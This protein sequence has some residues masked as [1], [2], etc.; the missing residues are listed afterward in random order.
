MNTTIEYAYN[1]FCEERFPI[2]SERQVADLER[3]M[4]ASFP[5]DYRDYL[6]RY[7]GGLFSEP[8]IEPP[9]DTCPADRLTFMSGI[10]AVLDCAELGNER[11]MSLFSDNDPIEILPIGYTMMGNLLA[12]VMLAQDR[13][14]ILLKKAFTDEWFVLADGIDEFFSLLHEPI[15]DG[16]RKGDK[17]N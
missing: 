17:S 3:R 1:A 11:D 14:A 9:M 2:P 15:D 4:R 6:L 10:G 5:D 13:G 16:P 12:V 7:N 8:D